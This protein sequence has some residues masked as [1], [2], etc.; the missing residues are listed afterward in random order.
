M[1]TIDLSKR[2][3]DILNILKDEDTISSTQ[4]ANVLKVSSRTIRNEINE[5]NRLLRRSCIEMKKGSGYKLVD[6]SVFDCIE[7]KK[8]ENRNLLILR[9]LLNE[10][11]LDFYDLA[12]EMYI[13]EAKLNKDVQSINTII[14][15]RNSEVRIERKNN[16][17]FLS[18]DETAQRQVCTYLLMNELDE[19]NFELENYENFFEEFSLDSIKRLVLDFNDR[20]GVLMK[21]MEVVS[22]VMHVSIMVDRV[23][24]NNEVIIPDGVSIDEHYLNLAKLFYEDLKQVVD[25]DMPENEMRYLATLFSGKTSTFYGQNLKPIQDFVISLVDEIKLQYEIDLTSDDQFIHNLQLH[26]FSLKNRLDNKTFLSNPLIHDIK[27]HF[28]VTYDISVFI[29]MK[30]QECFKV[31][32]QESEIG[33]ITLHLMGAIERINALDKV[34]LIVVSPLGESA[35]SYIRKQLTRIRDVQINILAI[36]SIFEIDKI[37]ALHPDLVVSFI[38]LT[39]K[40]NCPVYICDGLLSQNDLDK[41]YRMIQTS[42]NNV[43]LHAF[44]DEDLFFNHCNFD[45]KES[46]IR[47]ICK[48]LQKKNYVDE[49]YVDLVLKREE[50]APTAYGNY[51]AIPHPI[52]KKAHKNKIAVMLLNQPIVWNDQKV[53]IIFLFSLSKRR[54]EAFNQ[55]F[56]KLVSLLDDVNKVKL[57]LKSE[58]LK[59]FLEAFDL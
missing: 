28:P 16:E 29:G 6:F 30:I 13:S 5:I 14:A 50:I 7:Y 40:L 51:F 38:P 25:I 10:K 21:D 35:N 17:L 55:L 59:E 18:G 47:F 2:Q 9:K 48:E 20:N 22:F 36:L 26:L 15:S 58:D 41:I 42:K 11:S 49:T 37:D 56:K 32:M 52:E 27:K 8:D 43:D 53:R 57:L 34:Q 46:A 24:Q 1:H 4:L 19:Y 3:M 23:L 39:K 45:S 12:D 54:D 44:F 33:F 31:A